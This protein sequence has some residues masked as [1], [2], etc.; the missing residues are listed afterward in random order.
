MSERVK[1]EVVGMAWGLAEKRGR[2]AA[3]LEAAGWA[4]EEAD[5]RRWNGDI[6]GA[7]A[8]SLFSARLRTA[9]E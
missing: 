5:A 8:M 7:A 3:L 6:Y 1:V 9:A 2:K 4:E